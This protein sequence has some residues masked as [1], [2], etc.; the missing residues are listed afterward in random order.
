MSIERKIILSVGC[1]LVAFFLFILLVETNI[2][3]PGKTDNALANLLYRDWSIS[4]RTMSFSMFFMSIAP[5]TLTFIFLYFTAHKIRLIAPVL[6]MTYIASS[7][8][9]TIITG[10]SILKE[11]QQLDEILPILYALAVIGLS[12]FSFKSAVNDARP[13]TT[14]LLGAISTSAFVYLSLLIDLITTMILHPAIMRDGVWW[15]VSF[16]LGT[17]ILYLLPLG[18]CVGMLVGWHAQRRKS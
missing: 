15:M 7:I 1:V 4:F 8:F 14:F 17:L 10:N 11:W 18:G 6:A 3:S 2:F 16:I 9:G 5:L 12:I 13:K